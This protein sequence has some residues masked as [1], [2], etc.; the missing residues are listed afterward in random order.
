ML[1]QNSWRQKSCLR[2][3]ECRLT[4]LSGET[5]EDQGEQIDDTSIADRREDWGD[6]LPDDVVFIT[7]GVD[8]EDDRSELEIVGWGRHEE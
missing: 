2:R 3:Y 8:A 1:P 4:S 6:N 5:W 7:C